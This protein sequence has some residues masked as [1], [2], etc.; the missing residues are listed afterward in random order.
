MPA[1]LNGK[2]LQIQQLRLKFEVFVA[3]ARAWR[4]VL[5]RT[6][7]VEQSETGMRYFSQ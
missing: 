1:L 4:A 3:A 2:I 7:Q 6:R 5:Q